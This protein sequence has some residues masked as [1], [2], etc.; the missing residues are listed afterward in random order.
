LEVLSGVDS[1]FDAEQDK[2]CEMDVN[3]EENQEMSMKTFEDQVQ[4]SPFL[5][6]LALGES[7]N[8]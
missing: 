2:N 6:N 1:E 3:D 7:N 5:V 8:P 4:Y